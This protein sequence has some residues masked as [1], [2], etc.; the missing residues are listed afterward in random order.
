MIQIGC[1]YLKT[2]IRIGRLYLK[3]PIVPSIRCVSHEEPVAHA[4]AGLHCHRGATAFEMTPIYVTLDARV[5]EII[6]AL[7]SLFSFGPYEL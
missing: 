6:A 2:I 3:L 1:L 4:A 5:L 7:P